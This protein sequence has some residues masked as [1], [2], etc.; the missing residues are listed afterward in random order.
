MDLNHARL[1][2]PPHPHAGQIHF[3]SPW[4]LK[5]T[6][7]RILEACETFWNMSDSGTPRENSRH[8]FI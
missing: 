2:I 7:A 8:T 6:A 5:S 4:H 3:S 1:P